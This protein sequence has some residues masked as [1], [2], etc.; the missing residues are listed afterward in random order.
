MKVLQIHVSAGTQAVFRRWP[1][2][3][4]TRS[5][6]EDWDGDLGR[7]AE[8]ALALQVLG[9]KSTNVGLEITAES[10]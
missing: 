2:L 8:Q 7:A 10:N 3:R 5:R 6:A 1:T 4:I 9:V